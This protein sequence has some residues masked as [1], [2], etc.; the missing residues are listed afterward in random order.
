MEAKISEDYPRGHQQRK[1][2]R[3]FFTKKLER[4]FQEKQLQVPQH[5]LNLLDVPFASFTPQDREL[6]EAELK[7]LSF[8]F[9]EQLMEV[10][11]TMGRPKDGWQEMLT[12]V[13]DS[14][15]KVIAALVIH[16]EEKI[17]SLEDPLDILEDTPPLA[18]RKEKIVVRTY[19]GG[20]SKPKENKERWWERKLF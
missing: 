1:I 20:E 2:V 3:S 7:P 11:D 10:Y 15:A 6:Y 8:V 9:A 19:R 18:P 13:P 14:P 17:R 4:K 5:L 12:R 16:E